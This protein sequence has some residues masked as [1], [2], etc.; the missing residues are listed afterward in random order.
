MSELIIPIQVVQGVMAKLGCRMTHREVLQKMFPEQES[1]LLQDPDLC[2]AFDE[3][4]GRRAWSEE[5]D[6]MIDYWKSAVANDV[7][8]YGRGIALK[9]LIAAHTEARAITS[10]VETQV[11]GPTLGINLHRDPEIPS[12]KSLHQLKP[13]T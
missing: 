10:M 2:I 6:L 11:K 5:A 3:V 13:G 4:V 1:D 12:V 9:D 7:G 8:P